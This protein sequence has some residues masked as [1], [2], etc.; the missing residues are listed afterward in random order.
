MFCPPPVAKPVAE[1]VFVRIAMRRFFMKPFVEKEVIASRNHPSIQYIRRLQNRVARDETE[2]FC[3]EG[4]RFIAQATA[5]NAPLKTLIYAP[6]LLQGAFVRRLIA[7][8][9]RRGTRCLAVTP[10]VLHSLTLNDDPQGIM[11][12]ARQ[13]WR[14]LESVDPMQGL[15]WIALDT[16]QSPGNL[17]TIVRTCDAVG[18]AGVL[19]IGN[20]VDAYHPA[21]VRATMGALFNVDFVRSSARDFTAW[22]QSHACTL[23][24]TSPAA[25]LEYNAI[26]YRAPTVLWMGWERK[27][28]SLEQQQM[29]DVM[30]K[31]PMLGRSDSLNLAVATGVMLYEILRQR[32][33]VQ[34]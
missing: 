3:V 11:A 6:E 16:I 25:A 32:R 20:A 21:C 18:A 23:V 30:V 8:N 33:A 12:V 22:M 15:C 14:G 29:C 27:G 2:L 17:G 34:E 19:L 28:L 31:I 1:R 7:T 13:Q 24:G 26:A 9:R 4:V 10:A 5:Q